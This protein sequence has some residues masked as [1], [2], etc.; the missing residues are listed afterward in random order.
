MGRPGNLKRG[1]FHAV[2]ILCIA[3]GCTGP[4]PT[5]STLAGCAPTLPNGDTPAGESPRPGFFGNGRLYTN[6]LWAG[7]EI[8]V[9]PRMVA[10]DGSIDVKFAW[11][12]APGV[13]AAGD[14]QI[15]GHET[16]TGAGIKAVIPDGYG[17]GFQATGITFPTE[18]CY[19]I[20]ARSGDAQ[21]T[22]V[23]K[24]TRVAG[25]AVPAPSGRLRRPS[26]DEPIDI[27]PTIA[28]STTPCATVIR[29]RPCGLAHR[30]HA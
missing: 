1:T 24:V 25:S 4:S 6:A 23:V 12:R 26:A 22:L 17:Q 21:L 14:L 8:L 13:G 18:G 15:A 7:G 19:E 2:L 29:R 11:W 5:M 9:D 3:V 27:V 30:G 10:A 16:R 28:L 20:T